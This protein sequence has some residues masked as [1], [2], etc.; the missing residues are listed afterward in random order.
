V[1]RLNA[2][3]SLKVVKGSFETVVKIWCRV[4]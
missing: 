2:K 4:A 3:R 1:F